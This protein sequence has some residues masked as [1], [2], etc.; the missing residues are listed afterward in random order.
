MS[1]F[2]REIYTHTELS[3]HRNLQICPWIRAALRWKLKF[4]VLTQ[5]MNHGTCRGPTSSEQLSQQ[6]GCRGRGQILPCFHNGRGRAR[7]GGSLSNHGSESDPCGENKLWHLTWAYGGNERVLLLNEWLGGW[8]LQPFPPIHTLKG[9]DFLLSG[10]LAPTCEI[11]HIDWK[12]G[13]CVWPEIGK[14]RRKLD[15][16]QEWRIKPSQ[17]AF[18]LVVWFM[19]IGL[20]FD[21]V[22][23]DFLP[24]FEKHLF[25]E[26]FNKEPYFHSI[27]PHMKKNKTKNS[28]IKRDKD[29]IFLTRVQKAFQLHAFV[30]DEKSYFEGMNYGCHGDCVWFWLGALI[31]GW[32][33]HESAKTTTHFASAVTIWEIMNSKYFFLS[34]RRG[35]MVVQPSKSLVWSDFLLVSKRF[36]SIFTW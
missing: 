5:K 36:W 7:S 13:S 17:S 4:A 20:V 2:S 10:I 6:A 27:L 14:N 29:A 9:L 22:S 18:P 23:L 30:R 33:K 1:C 28:L 19:H 8:T 34:L 35:H 31:C 3:N 15:K 11:V 21:F 16:I 12:V 25:S 24:D 32:P 26:I